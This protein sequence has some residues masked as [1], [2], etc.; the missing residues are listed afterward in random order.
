[1]NFFKRFNDYSCIYDN[2]KELT[3][4]SHYTNSI[5]AVLNICKGCFWMTE[6]MDF[7]NDDPKEGVLILEKVFDYI[8]NNI[9]S[10]EIKKYV[11]EFIGDEQSRKKFLK[12][13]HTTFVL[14]TCK[15]NN[16]NT[17]WENYAKED[18]YRIEVDFKKFWKSIS[19]SIKGL[20][21]KNRNNEIVKYAPIIYEEKKQENLVMKEFTDLINSQAFG[22]VLKEKVK[23]ILQHLMYVGNFYKESYFFEEEEVRFVINTM[24]YKDGEI[25]DLMPDRELNKNNNKHYIEMKFDPMAIILVEC[26]SEK[27]KIKFLSKSGEG[28]ETKVKVL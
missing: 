18:G 25:V 13:D 17:M 10:P 4:L 28:W 19:V 12:D 26:K 16:S 3:T 23:Y 5:D 2:K 8:Q 1:M 21:K 22:I 14:S 6:I 9:E 15:N 11:T 24:I 27:A 20:N 7:G